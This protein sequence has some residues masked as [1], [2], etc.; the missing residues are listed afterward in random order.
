MPRSR[1]RA[2]RRSSTGDAKEANFCFTAD[3]RAAAAVDFQY[4]GRGCGM[5]DVAYLLAGHDDAHVETYFAA[6]RE[7]LGGATAVPVE[8]EW[9]GLYR[10]AQR[11][12]QRF[13]AGWRG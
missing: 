7:A 13:F 1:P 8:A 12:L 2:T 6:L 4:A 3:A 5:K 10:T 11:D 9:R